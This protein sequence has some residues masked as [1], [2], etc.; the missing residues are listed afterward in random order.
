MEEVQI[1]DGPAFEG[2]VQEFYEKYR[3]CTQCLHW[4]VKVEEFSPHN[5][6]PC[7][8]QAACKS[9]RSKNARASYARKN[10][11]MVNLMRKESPK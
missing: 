5:S 2:T 9:C 4:K 11:T 7:G 10:P 8:Y 3:K 1:V 6:R